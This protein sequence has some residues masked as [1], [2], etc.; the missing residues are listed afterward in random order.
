MPMEPKKFRIALALQSDAIS[1]TRHFFLGAHQFAHTQPDWQ[2]VREDNTTML[3]W[4]QAIQS[5]PDGIL[6][7]LFGEQQRSIEPGKAGDVQ[8]VILN[9]TNTD[10]PFHKV[11]SNNTEIGRR[12]AMHLIELHLEN[13]AF[14]GFGDSV[15]SQQRQI[16]F[17]EGLQKAG[18]T[19]PVPARTI[20][21]CGTP[22]GFDQWLKNLPKPCGIFCANDHVGAEVI[23]ACQ[24]AGIAVPGEIAVLGASNDELICAA[25]PITLSSIRQN[26]EIV[27]YRAAAFLDRLLR[28]LPTP[29]EPVLVP[30]GELIVR[31]STRTFAVGD[32]LVRRALAIIH[33]EPVEPLKIQA[34]LTRLGNV[35]Q[36]LLEIRF[37]ETLGRSPYQEILHA[38]V[39][40]A[41]RWLRSTHESLEEIAYKTGFSDPARFSRHFRKI[42][43]VT[44]SQYRHSHQADS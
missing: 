4:E 1:S 8:V 7:V 31:E 9:Q 44:P 39:N 40:F 22:D 28:G 33:D 14:I 6:G 11:V 17:L 18:C 15:F 27:G 32:P 43:G 16:G 36:R 19:H 24:Q 25:A 42:C 30:S 37:K 3:N 21:L 34:L 2:I 26:F 38:R 13:F 35:S 23:D 29:R 5:Q 20:D 12:A 10:H 41:K